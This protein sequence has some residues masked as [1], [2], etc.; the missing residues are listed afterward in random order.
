[1]ASAQQ[2]PG[3]AAAAP[4]PPG[5]RPEAAELIG[6]ALARLVKL[7]GRD[8]KLAAIAAA[9]KELEDSL[10]EVRRAPPRWHGRERG[11]ACAETS[12]E[13]RVWA[14]PLRDGLQQ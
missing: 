7:C 9:A 2:P 6:S 8:R 4:P 5:A 11:W 3:A 13:A 1:M 14:A 10:L 12:A